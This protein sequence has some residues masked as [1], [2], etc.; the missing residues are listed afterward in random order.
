MTTKNTNTFKIATFYKFI[1]L[2][3][4]ELLKEELLTTA[5]HLNIKGTILI[6]S[7]GLNATICAESENLV[8]YLEYLQ[9]HSQI[10]EITN[11]KYSYADFLPFQ[12][13]KVKFKKEIVSIG[14]KDKTLGFDVE[15]GEYLQALEWNK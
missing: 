10:N 3:N 4:L 8:Q 15:T 13:M 12:K 2:E 11:I 7:E 9:H 6:A 1:K 5:K 14:F